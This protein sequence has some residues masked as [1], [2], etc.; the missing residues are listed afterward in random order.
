MTR[1]RVAETL[2]ISRPVLE[3]GCPCYPAISPQSAEVD[4]R[5]RDSKSVAYEIRTKSAESGGSET[6]GRRERISGLSQHVAVG[7]FVR[8]ARGYWASCAPESPQ[9]VLVAEELAEGEDLPTNSLCVVGRVA[10]KRRVVAGPPGE[11]P[12][13]A[14]RTGATHDRPNLMSPSAAEGWPFPI[15]AACCF[16]CLDLSKN[17][18][19][20]PRPL[21]TLG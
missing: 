13:R 21:V 8:E 3:P 15:F 11:T 19:H 5:K 17:V 2:G 16:R 7:R 1:A 4:V 18:C 14:R 9:R 6:N 10:A 12:H 20:M